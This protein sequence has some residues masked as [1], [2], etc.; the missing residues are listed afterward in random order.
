VTDRL[1]GIEL[2]VFDKDGTLIEFHAMWGGWAVALADDLESATGAAIRE[3]LFEMLGYDA[4][5]GRA[6][7]GGRLAATPMARIREATAGVLRDAG[8]PEPAIEPALQIAWHAPDAVGLAQPVTDLSA[9]FAALRSDGRRIAVATTDDREP[10]MRTLAALGL[11]GW[12]DAV[13][14]ADDGLPVKPAGDMVVSICGQL[15]IGPG[16][17]AVVGDSVADLA[18]GR[19]AGVARC[20]GVLTGVGTRLDLAPLADEVIDSVADLRVG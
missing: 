1:E 6:I 3:P 14:C 2:V 15:G 7:G 20:Y 18:M 9:L 13:A 19:S 10:T 11:T 5:A 16:R 8:V 4:A 12:V 17:T